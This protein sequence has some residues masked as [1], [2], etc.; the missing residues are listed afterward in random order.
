MGV[1]IDLAGVGRASRPLAG[2]WARLNTSGEADL[3]ELKRARR[4]LEA[5]PPQPGRLGRAVAVVAS[6]GRS[7]SEDETVAAVQLLS[8][9]QT[10]AGEGSSVSSRSPG[11]D[12][13]CQARTGQ[14]ALAA[15]IRSDAAD[16][17]CSARPSRGPASL[18]RLVEE[19]ARG[20]TQR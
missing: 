16:R 9:T 6:G 18:A 4:L 17:P 13:G 5:L 2:W 7:A 3:Y 15:L 19:G 11:S 8:L 20:T 12:E 1:V 10:D 14:L